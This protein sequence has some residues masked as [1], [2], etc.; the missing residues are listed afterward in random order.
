MMNY[1]DRTWCN[2]YAECINGATCNR[3]LTDKIKANAIKWWGSEDAPLCIFD[4]K[5]ECFIAKENT[6]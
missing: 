6:N 5:P 4:G 1:M 3:A 2:I